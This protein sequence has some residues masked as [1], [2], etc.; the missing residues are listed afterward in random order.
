MVVRPSRLARLGGSA[1]IRVYDLVLN[2]AEISVEGQ[3]KEGE[4]SASL[5]SPE[6]FSEPV[7]EDVRDD[8]LALFGL[9]EAQFD[10]A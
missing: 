8:I 1:Q 4:L 3:S 9:S 7:P 6:T 10:P 5:A 2:E